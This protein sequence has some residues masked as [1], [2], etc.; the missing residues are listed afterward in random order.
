MRVEDGAVRGLDLHFARLASATRELFGS[1]LDVA[2]LRA[3]LR[4]A[5]TAE[6]GHLSVRVNVFSRAFD[7]AHPFASA[8]PDVLISVAAAPPDE[9]T[10]LRLK[11]FR[12]GR[13]LPHIK[14]VGTFPLFHFRGLAQRDGYDDALFVDAD[15]LI[16]EASIWNIGFYDGIRVVWPQAP[17][18]DGVGMRLLRRGLAQLGVTDMARPVRLSD[19]R[20]FHG[21]FLSN[22]AAFARLVAAI[23]GV[24]FE[25]NADLIDLLQRAHLSNPPQRL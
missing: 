10:S 15:G 7:R 11:S 3:W 13:E 12:Y 5:V 4:A 23:D 18:L 24:Q 17:Q 19:L 8:P 1:D 6:R 9:S 21:A 22:T 2:Q 20:D 14:H 16:S 25:E